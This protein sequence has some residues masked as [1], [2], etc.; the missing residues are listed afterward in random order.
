MT[1]NK[2]S[3]WV[4]A[5]RLFSLPASV[6]PV[7][8]A[9]AYVFSLQQQNGLGAD[10]VR[11]WLLPLILLAGVSYHLGAN[12]IS[13]FHDWK[14]GV[15]QV[16][17]Y[18]SSRVLVEGELP[19]YSFLYAGYALVGLGTVIGFVMIYFTGW[20][21]FWF[22]LA[23]C[24][25]GIFYTQIKYIALGELLIFALFGLLMVAGTVLVLTGA[26]PHEV[27]L[28]ALPLACLTTGILLANNIR[29]ILHD[30]RVPIKTMPI[31]LGL[32]FAK[33][34]YCVLLGAAYITVALLV[35]VGIVDYGSLL[36]F[37][38]VPVAIKNV[39]YINRARISQPALVRDGDAMTARLQ[40]MF[41]M[42]FISGIMVDA[43]VATNSLITRLL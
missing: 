6:M 11:W 15:D 4:K 17:T 36:V 25:G 14:N 13:D 38:T 30:R 20:A 40:M 29:D 2:F 5:L 19:P 33:V 7:L 9:S 27:W 34:E 37:L 21:L 28:L 31:I 12:L 1:E 41:S 39:R 35:Y 16:D 10:Q 8:L 32:K 26:L 42:V 22:G 3:T 24:L 43:F 18:G 23:G